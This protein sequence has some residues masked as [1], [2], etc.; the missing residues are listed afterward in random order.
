[1]WTSVSPCRRPGRVQPEVDLGLLRRQEHFLRVVARGGPEPE[2]RRGRLA[3][4][5]HA[6]APL[7]EFETRSLK[8]YTHLSFK[9]LVSGRGLHSF[10][11]QFNLIS[12][13]HRMTQIN[14]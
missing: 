9:R 2:L 3:G 8:Q 14:P 12:S 10:P 5:H 7:L 1:M 6:V 13:V 11:F 4:V